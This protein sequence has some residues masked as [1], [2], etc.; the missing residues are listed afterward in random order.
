MMTTP[1]PSPIEEKIIQA[2]IQCIEQYGVQ[3]TTTRRIA[4]MARVNSAAVNYYFRSKEALIQRCMQVTLENAFDFRDFARL[5]AGSAGEFC[6]AIFNDLIQGGCSFPG[7][8]RAHFY[9]LLTAGRYDSLAVE[10]LNEFIRQLSEELTAKGL[11]LEPSELHLALAQLT[12]ASLMAILAPGLFLQSTGI[13][14][15]D[16]GTRQRFV[17]R[18][19]ERLF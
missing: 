4:E 14:L 6:A 3:G 9:E 2:A 16:E 17:Q 8:S 12:Y 1:A 13:D 5:P 11:G 18:L 19:V 7:I 10:K 15:R